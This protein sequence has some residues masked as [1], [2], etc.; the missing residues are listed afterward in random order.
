MISCGAGRWRRAAQFGNKYQLFTYNIDAK[1]WV[2]TTVFDEK[3]EGNAKAKWVCWPM[4]VDADFR[5]LVPLF[6]V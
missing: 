4:D 3:L 1:Y 6:Q 2:R 5:P